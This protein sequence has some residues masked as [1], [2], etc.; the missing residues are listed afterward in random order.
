[1]S[2]DWKKFAI[3]VIDIALA[4]YLLLAVM[5]FNKPDGQD[6][7]CTRVDIRIAD[8]L[9]NGFLGDA[10][11]ESQLKAND[12]YPLGQ[13]LS[14]V[15]V[16]DIEE[17]LLRNPFVKEAQCY[18]TQGGKVIVLLTQRLPVLHIKAMNGDDYYLDGRGNVMPNT[19]YTSDLI[20]ATGHI[21]R[22]Y[23]KQVLA[24][25]GEDL[26]QNRFWNNQI[27]QVNVLRDGSMELVP[28][29]GDHIVYLGSPTDISKKLTRLEKFY[30][31]GLNVA[32]WN[33]YSYIN[34]E[35]SNQIICKKRETRKP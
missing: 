6:A 4:V 12:L 29:V 11:V 19:R 13:P 26:V 7:V 15:N 9:V 10:E 27:E 16:R 3:V 23:A 30:R 5:V 2:V 33:K 1:M 28:R 25:I 35:F 17:T 22:N 31:Y 8:G 20:V 24:S 32:G 34:M 21:S 14:Q 18:K